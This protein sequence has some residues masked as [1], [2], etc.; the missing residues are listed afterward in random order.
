VASPDVS[1]S[2][3]SEKAMVLKVAV[4]PYLLG[5]LLS[6]WI[7]P[8]HLHDL[9]D[10]SVEAVTATA[11]RDLSESS[12]GV[13]D[14]SLD[15][16][17]RI[18]ELGDPFANFRFVLHRN[19][20]VD[21]CAT[22]ATEGLYSG[23]KKSAMEK[24]NYDPSSYDKYDFD[25]LLTEAMAFHFLLIDECG[26]YEGAAKASENKWSRQVMN[27]RKD[28]LPTFV[29]FCDTGPKHTPILPDHDKLVNV[30]LG[31]NDVSY[32]CAYHTRE[33]VR[34]T[35]L[36]QLA[37]LAR[38]VPPPDAESCNPQEGSS[39]ATCAAAPVRELHLYAVPAGRVFMFAPSY[40][41]EVFELPHVKVASGRPVSLE[42]LSLSPRVFDVKNFYSRD[43]SAEIVKKALAETS[44]SHK[45][46]RSSTGA[47]GY[48]INS[49][50]TSENGFDTHGR[51][52][53]IVKRRC[54]NVLGLD[55]YVE[56]MADGLQVLRYNKTTAYVPHLDWI[57]DP[58]RRQEH[59]FDSEGVGS[60]RF[61]T[62]LLYM[63]DLGEKDGGETVFTEG[64]P[65][66]M[67]EE[68]RIPYEKA[69]I[70]L[71]G[72]GDAKDL[73]KGSWEE[74]M[75]AKCRSRLAIR[76]HSSRA[77]LFYSQLPNGKPDKAS[78]HGG[79]P[80]LGDD[81]KWAANLWVWNAPRGGY[82]G[83]PVNED[84]VKKNRAKGAKEEDYPG[85]KHAM[86]TNRGDDSRFKNAK[87]H[88]QDTFWGDLGFGDP[89]LAVNTY[90]GH[91]WNVMVDGKTLQS[92][93]IDKRPD[94]AYFI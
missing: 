22:S 83:S 16:M 89:P 86:F 88:F 75:V 26:P 93:V 3:M 72:S 47:S 10:A 70:E 44:E 17:L 35:S 77:V 36:G 55:E 46:K 74:E 45:I 19:G 81:P 4:V 62:I 37:D 82:P 90:E 9:G 64:W 33:G 69:L 59:N 76:P 5:L 66:G 8:E 79:C 2:S 15:K 32:P 61:A 49:R 53:M 80:V 43:E 58:G 25:A 7:V 21:P 31:G 30:N 1:L 6:P 42:V 24:Y 38:Q 27:G 68:E 54:F 87:L 60:N 78:L 57:D 18:D 29:A 34:I 51:V 92:F 50:R 63:S 11:S 84:V 28:A 65:S 13:N 73:A 41:G 52:A 20:E 12:A 71:R 23:I 40:V 94:Q 14:A 85:K 91:V 39:D 56:S 67:P 48:N